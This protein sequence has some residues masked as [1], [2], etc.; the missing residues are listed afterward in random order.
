VQAHAVNSYSFT[1]REDGPWLRGCG[2]QTGALELGIN[3]HFNS[4]LKIMFEYLHQDRYNK[5][6]APN[7]TLPG[8]VDGFGIRTQFFF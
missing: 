4:N 2:G 3:W 6:T 7:G 1:K 8:D 5:A